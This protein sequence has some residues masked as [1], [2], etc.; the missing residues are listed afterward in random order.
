[1]PLRYRFASL[2]QGESVAHLPPDS[3]NPS[4]WRQAQANFA[5]NGLYKVKDGIYQVR[6]VDLSSATFIRSNTGW[7]VYDVLMQ[8]KPM[9]LALDFFL[10]NVPKGGDL[11]LWQCSILTPTP[12][13]LA[14]LDQFMSVFL[15]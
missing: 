13:T 1:M 15:M 3:V 6:G 2:H 14:A 7:I 8:D 9:E 10:N 4:L 12:I 11:P 5:A